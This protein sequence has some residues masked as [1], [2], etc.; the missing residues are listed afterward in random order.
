MNINLL[1]QVINEVS[2]IKDAGG[3]KST[4]KPPDTAETVNQ[5]TSIHQPPVT[6]DQ[7]PK[8][9]TEMINSTKAASKES[10]V[11]N[12]KIVGQAQKLLNGKIPIPPDTLI[13]TDEATDIIVNLLLS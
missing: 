7:K 8:V 13:T 11:K 4:P 12:S 2:N 3:N 1:Q 6:G 5:Q 9:D 10:T